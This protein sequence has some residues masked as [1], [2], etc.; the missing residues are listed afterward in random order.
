MFSALIDVWAVRPI[1]QSVHG[2][3]NLVSVDTAVEGTV[4]AGVD[5]A[6]LVR[7]VVGRARAIAAAQA[8]TC[9]QDGDEPAVHAVSARLDACDDRARALA[10]AAGACDE[11]RRAAAVEFVADAVTALALDGAWRPGVA[12]K[13]VTA[14]AAEIDVSPGAALLAVFMRAVANNEVAQLPPR[15]AA[16]FVLW[17][18]VELGP[19]D[20]ASLWTVG[21]SERTECLVAAGD[22]PT[23][24]RLREAATAT[25]AGRAGV[26][27]HVQA[28]AVQRWDKMFGSIV[29]RVHSCESARLG[30]WLR[31]ASAAL[32][33]LLERETLFERNAARE[34][35][36]VSASERR[37]TRL[38][39][40]LHDGPLQEI[41]ALAEDLRLA[42]A[43]IAAL[44]DEP[45]RGR[46]CG[47]FDDLEARLTSLDDGLR[48]VA[49]SIRSTPAV[50][51]PLEHVLRGEVDALTRSSGITA[52]FEAD[53]DLSDLTESQKIVLYRMVQEALTNIRK[54]SAATRA[55]VRV[56]A[57]PTYIELIVADNGRGF[58]LHSTVARALLADRLGLAGM[59]ER[60]RLLGGA[61][62]IEARVGEGVL[63]RAT[64]PRWRPLAAANR[65]AVYA[66]TG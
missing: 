48:Q 44:L 16:E 13:T 21:E 31:E 18:L 2:E 40:D 4:D 42:R 11:A 12:H 41:V 52:T 47:R 46:A 30:A 32:S 20:A 53:G 7:N 60:V 28:V 43:Q 36:L 14:A 26:S 54:H 15:V 34:R 6:A 22:A 38:G 1:V 62:E 51:R 3:Q 55:D 5:E 66:A 64:L 61:V 17:A 29:A 50:V 24:R 59:S 9:P 56:R 65:T 58:D 39:F 8:R 49:N 23:S 63:V 35:E 57:L 10:R 37:L 27:P 33:P 25:L 45:E 19:A